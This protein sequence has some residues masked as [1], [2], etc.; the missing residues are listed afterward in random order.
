[1][2]SVDEAC[3][4]ALPSR[5][6]SGYRSKQASRAHAGGGHAREASFTA[7]SLTKGQQANG[8]NSRG[9]CITDEIND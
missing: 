7:S 2:T 8:R 4:C 6:S 5:S 9:T 1:M 3:C